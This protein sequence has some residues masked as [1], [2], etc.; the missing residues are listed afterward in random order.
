M[1]TS[2]LFNIVGIDPGNNLGVSIIAVDSNDFSIQHITSF[3]IRLESHIPNDSSNTLLDKWYVIEKYI[4]NLLDTYNPLV[5]GMESAFLNSRFP[6]A[7][8]NLSSYTTMIEF[9]ISKYSYNLIKIWKYP[10]K[11]IKKIV[12]TGNADKLDM[13][14]SVS[15]IKEIKQHIDLY[16]VTEHE[17]DATAIA[18]VVLDEIRK[19]P[20]TLLCV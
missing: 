16:N 8:I 14:H 20:Y 4:I 15:S 17:V 2:P 18:Y 3:T 13:L 6:K 10:P 5:V 19:N 1:F 7:V 11:Y 12:S 9:T